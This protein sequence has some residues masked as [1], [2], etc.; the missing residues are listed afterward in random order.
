VKRTDWVTLF[1]RLALGTAFLSGIAS[2]FGW[3][4][5]GVGYGSWANFVKYTGQ[6]NAFMPR[7]TIP[8]LAVAA[9]AAELVL[10]VLLVAGVRLRW[11][12]LASAALLALFGVAMAI[13]FG[14]K[15]PLDYSVFSA[16][17]AALLLTRRTDEAHLART[18]RTDRRL[19]G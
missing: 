13:S 2:R 5:A 16:C 8:F 14:P 11:T 18:S 7:E 10:G 4:G 1:A 9:T 12:A 17:A 6:V 15:E 19:I 3:W